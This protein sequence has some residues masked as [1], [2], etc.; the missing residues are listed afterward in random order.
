MTSLDD[1]AERLRL[2]G[3]DAFSTKDFERAV[4]LYQRSAELGANPKTATK[5]YSN[6]AATLCKLSRFDEA[7]IAAERATILDPIWAKA[8]WRR[9]VVAE[10]Q[11]LFITALKYYAMAVQLEPKEKTFSKA[12]KSMEKR[13][14]VEKTADG[15]A[16]IQDRRQ[17][18]QK[19]ML[20]EKCYLV[21]ERLQASVPGSPDLAA[22]TV[23]YYANLQTDYPTS[24]QYLIQGLVDW[25]MGLKSAVAELALAL[26]SEARREY[27]AIQQQPLAQDVS[28]DLV[29]RS[30]GGMP[31]GGKSLQQLTAGFTHLGGLNIALE[32]GGPQAQAQ[33]IRFCTQPR[34][35]S[36]LPM[37]QSIA[38]M[39]SIQNTLQHIV[40]VFG[41]DLKSSQAVMSASTTFKANIGHQNAKPQGGQ[42]ASPTEVVAYIKQ[43]LQAGK[44]WDGGVRRFVSLQYRGTILYGVMIRLL[45][46]VAE[47][48]R[49]DRWAHEF[50]T[51]ADKEFR[52]TE[53]KTYEEKGS[54]FR[55]SFRIG[56]MCSELQSLNALRGDRIDGP[57]PISLSLDLCLEI[58]E[59]ADTMEVTSNGQGALAE[60]SRIQNVVGWHRKPLALAHSVIASHLNILAGVFRQQDFHKIVSG[61][62]LVK[63]DDDLVDPF[64][65]IVKHY[66]LAAEAELPDAEDA[67]IYWWAVG[68]NMA[69]AEAK[70]GYTLGDLQLVI[71]KAEEAERA[72]DVGLFGPNQQ[73]GAT[74]ETL[75]K[76]TA[77]YFK[78]ELNSFVLP[79][80]EIFRGETHS[81]LRVG[82]EV[83][84]KDYDAY[85]QKEMKRMLENRQH[86]EVLDTSDVDK[87]FGP[88]LDELV[89]SL[90]TLCIRE[91][92]KAECKFAAG[93]TDAA[94]IY[95]KAMMAA[96]EEAE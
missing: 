57:Y 86:S 41:P 29:V 56:M 67:A 24:E 55:P 31:N 33:P 58:A 64:A 91:L 95:C 5:T 69:R 8:W 89:P 21:W 13:L 65:L 38:L 76:L 66:R 92:H 61:H 20:Q 82:D 18:K 26:S 36:F 46:H 70:S 51:L 49:W 84:C 63:E 22:Y 23:Q 50:I 25:V 12:L 73:R 10:L 88:E 35:L 32:T 90:E 19:D 30:L 59:M 72:R 7:S 16:T 53:E 9:G 43:Q 71:S 52:V 3:N 17:R 77:E 40:S 4:D 11:K 68:A 15:K 62:G 75:S 79:Q 34:Y 45:G 80:V 94:V 60:Y 47:A 14:G 6:L 48:Y 1:K 27:Q 54:A 93:E 28:L 37:Y 42:E 39:F 44:T 96:Q 83:I 87:K 74:Y 81:S 85:E 2:Q 78:S